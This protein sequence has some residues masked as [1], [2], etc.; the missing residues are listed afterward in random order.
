MQVFN[1]NDYPEFDEVKEELLLF[2]NKICKSKT[3]YNYYLDR[4]IRDYNSGYYGDWESFYIH[5]IFEILDYLK[6]INLKCKRKCKILKDNLILK[7][8]FRDNI[9][10]YLYKPN[11]LRYY[12]IKS[13]FDLSLIDS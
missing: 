12:L 6:E 13:H 10:H 9:N 4:Y 7:K 1:D 8:F 11:G 3:I 2:Q 5:N